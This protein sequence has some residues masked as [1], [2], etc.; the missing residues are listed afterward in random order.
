MT[1]HS[2]TIRVMIVDDHEVVRRGLASLI[3]ADDGLEVVASVGSAEEAVRACKQA[4]PDVILMDILL[5]GA[6]DGVAATAHIKALYPSVKILALTAA[7]DVR[8]MSS[9]IQA[10][11]TGYLLKSAPIDNLHHVIRM[12]HAGHF[13]FSPEA[14]PFLMQTSA[15]HNAHNLTDREL[16]V[17]R[18]LAKGLNNPE[19][20]DALVISRSTVSFHV[21]SILAKLNVTNRLEASVLAVRERLI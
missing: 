20:A 13:T 7:A 5:P 6:Q 10:G 8:T 4:L 2:Q 11:A 3:A 9:A 19:I 16:E 21:S 14:A 1:D 15:P 17:L 18:L 12:V